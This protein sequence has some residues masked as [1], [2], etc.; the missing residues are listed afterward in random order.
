MMGKL[1]G[2]Y[3]SIKNIHV[4]ARLGLGPKAVVGL[5]IAAALGGVGVGMAGFVN[6]TPLSWA[7]PK[8]V[9]ELAPAGVTK[10]ALN[11]SEGSEIVSA[12]LPRQ[13]QPAA[14]NTPS[15]LIQLAVAPSHSDLGVVSTPDAP[16]FAPKAFTL[17]SAKVTHGG[18]AAVLG[19]TARQVE[20]DQAG[21]PRTVVED[22]V[23]TALQDVIINAGETP[24]NVRAALQSIL[25]YCTTPP[26][27]PPNADKDPPLTCPETPASIDAISNLLKVVVAAIDQQDAPAAGGGS[28]LA[29]FSSAT[30][31]PLGTGGS[32]YQSF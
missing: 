32:N 1:F 16:T 23:K 12:S 14:A 6:A 7:S 5:L 25:L 9:V 4:S 2:L 31:P 8:L 26:N 19:Q 24:F 17:A 18:L 21:K 22:A 20:L 15:P 30:P 29:A 13:D 3:V 27:S 10:S 28:G 11:P